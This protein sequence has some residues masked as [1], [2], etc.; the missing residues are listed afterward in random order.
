[1]KDRLVRIALFSL[2]SGFESY[3][4]CRDR[5]VREQSYHIKERE[6]VESSSSSNEAFC[7]GRNQ[8]ECDVLRPRGWK[9]ERGR[10]AFSAV[11]LKG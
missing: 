2:V 10:A 8:V 3:L 9:A 11:T 1:M 5:Y 4:S 6:V 7:G